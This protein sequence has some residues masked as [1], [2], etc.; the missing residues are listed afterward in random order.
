LTVRV[1]NVDNVNVVLTEIT[2]RDRNNVII[3]QY[4]VYEWIS[5]GQTRTFVYQCSGVIAGAT[6]TVTVTGQASDGT[7]VTAQAQVTAT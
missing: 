3:C 6:Y 4:P 2:L 7:P 1:T 5:P